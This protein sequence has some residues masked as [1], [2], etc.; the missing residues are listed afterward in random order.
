MSLMTE[1]LTG[2]NEAERRGKNGPVG[3]GLAGE[4][5]DVSSAPGAA[6]PG[7]L[8]RLPEPLPPALPASCSMGM[9]CLHLW[10]SGS[11]I[12]E[13]NDSCGFAHELCSLSPSLV[14]ISGT[15]VFSVFLGFCTSLRFAPPE[16]RVCCKGENAKCKGEAH[17]WG[18]ENADTV[19]QP[20]TLWMLPANTGGW[21]TPPG[22]LFL[23]G[24]Y[25][26]NQTS[27]C[28]LEIPI[29]TSGLQT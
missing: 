5:G 10:V 13:G 29:T 18:L 3:R 11:V 26:I 19:P 24:Y 6:S 20:S 21:L 14:S 17:K 15:K 25:L 1:V 22:I 7:D 12:N 2:A 4:P 16:N 27:K 23:P 9:L 8:P 28:P